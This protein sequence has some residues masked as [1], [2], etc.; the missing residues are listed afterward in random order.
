MRSW[1]RKAKILHHYQSSG[2][3]LRRGQ[4]R[5]YQRSLPLLDNQEKLAEVAELH[6][7]YVGLLETRVAYAEP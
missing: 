5:K 4:R 1:E 7:H 2:C 3:Q 6:R